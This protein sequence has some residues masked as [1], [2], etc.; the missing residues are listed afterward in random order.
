MLKKFLSR[1]SRKTKIIFLIILVVFGIFLGKRIFFA[2][3]DGYVFDTVQKRDITEVVSE[4]GSV[5][6]SGN[7]PVYS[8]TT[9]LV[10]EVYVTPGQSVTE[11]QKLFSV[12]STATPAEKSA[13][14]AAYQVA[15]TAVQ[16]AE[17]TRRLTQATVQRVHDD[18]K[19]K[20]STENFSQRETRTTAEVANDNAYDALLAAQ[21]QL[22]SAQVAYWATQNSTLTAPVEGWISNLSV[23]TGSSVIAHNPLISSS[24]VLLISGLGTSEVVISVGESDINKIQVGQ[25][26]EITL[27]A[28]ADHVYHGKVTRVDTVGTLTQSVVKFNVY[29]E[30]TD[31][32]ERIKSGMTADVD[33]IT[34]QLSD[35]L[36]VPNTAVKPY[37]KGRA[38]RILKSGEIE[39]LPITVG[40]K[41]KEYTQITDGLSQGQEIIISLTNE[42]SKRSSS[43][44]F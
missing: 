13:A 31:A 7:I 38:V 20:G 23:V 36:S 18:L 5:T 9:G 2:S 21:A 24:P 6:S 4:S 15:V 28:V 41:G 25:T 26:A 11:R 32:D 44:G 10:T 40:I 42:K 34:R 33:I 1:F 3:K 29:L 43:F 22:T 27:D 30:F 14:Y 19:D 35:V 37:Q 39:Y 12:K 8:P 17:N 16:Q